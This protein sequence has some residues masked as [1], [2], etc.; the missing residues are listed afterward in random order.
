[1]D[2]S[3]SLPISSAWACQIIVVVVFKPVIVFFNLYLVPFCN[4]NLFSDILYLVRHYSIL[5]FS[6]S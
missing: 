3:L 5:S 1:M 4:F 6:S 2:L